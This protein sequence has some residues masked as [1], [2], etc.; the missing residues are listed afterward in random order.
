MSLRGRGR[1]AGVAPPAKKIRTTITQSIA[2]IARELLIP[3]WG[4][5]PEKMVLASMAIFMTGYTL[6]RYMEELGERIDMDEVYT[7]TKHVAEV[8]G[9]KNINYN[10]DDIF[11]FLIE[12]T[13]VR[14]NDTYITYLKRVGVI[15]T[16]I[17]FRIFTTPAFIEALIETIKQ[18]E[19]AEE[20]ST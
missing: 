16:S 10:Y 4:K 2:K 15:C 18:L 20:R 7:L 5:I 11:E 13:K 12:N 14:D 8:N 3:T 9:V 6:R 17:M 19:E 1:R